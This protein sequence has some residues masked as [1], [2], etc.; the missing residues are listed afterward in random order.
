[1]FAL[2]EMIQQCCRVHPGE[3]V[4]AQVLMDADNRATVDAFNKGLSRNPTTHKM[5]VR[6]FELQAEQGFRQKLSLKW[7][8][9][10]ANQAADGRSPKPLTAAFCAAMRDSSITTSSARREWGAEGTR[11]GGVPQCW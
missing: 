4:R 7:V 8:L 6:L 5:L 10:A 11:R 3:L 1:M 9:S 2:L